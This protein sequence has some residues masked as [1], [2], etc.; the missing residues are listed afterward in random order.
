M[1]ISLQMFMNNSALWT[2]I[3]QAFCTALCNHT[4]IFEYE[5]LVS[6]QL[7]RELLLCGCGGTLG[8]SCL[9]VFEVGVGNG[10]D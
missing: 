8:D 3:A 4:E 2:E 5:K 1:F 10:L 6:I 9:D 7:G